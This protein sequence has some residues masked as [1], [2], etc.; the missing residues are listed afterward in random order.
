MPDLDI[1][2]LAG[3]VTEYTDW[4]ATQD[5]RPWG[6][7]YYYLS[8]LVAHEGRRFDGIKIIGA[9]WNRK[10]AIDYYRMALAARVMKF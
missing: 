4:C 10:N 1:V 9:F 6:D 5:V 2:V 8:N 7:G 3:S